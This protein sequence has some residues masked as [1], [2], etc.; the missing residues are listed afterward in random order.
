MSNGI[1]ELVANSEKSMIVGLA[2][3]GTGKSTTFKHLIDSDHYKGKKIL[4]LS[5]IR[6]LV[7][8]LAND[9]R[10]Y[11]KVKVA[12]LHSFALGEFKRITAS[13]SVDLIE[14]LDDIISEDYGIIKNAEISY[15]DKICNLTMTSDEEDFYKLRRDYYSK[16]KLYSFNS[17]VYAVNKLYEQNDSRIPNEYDIILIDEFQ[18]FN[19][20]EY[21]F[22]KKLN[23]TTKTL[24]VGDDDQS[25]YD[26]KFAKPALIRDLYN[27]E[28]TDSFSLDNCY[29]C[30]RVIVD[31][32]NSLIVNAQA[33]GL[34]SER[35]NE[36]KYLYPNERKDD[37][38]ELSEIYSK[39]DFMPKLQ[40]HQLTYQLAAKIKKDSSSYEKK[41]EKPARVLV[42][43]PHFLKNKL[44]DGLIDKGCNVVNYEL[45]SDEKLNKVK[46]SD[47]CKVLD[48]LYKRKT[49]DLMLRKVLH[50][51][52]DKDRMEDVIRNGFAKNKKIWSLLSDEEKLKIKEDIRIFRKAKIGKHTLESFELQR[53]SEIF[54]LKNLISKMIAGFGQVDSGAQEVG[55][56]TVMESKG[57]SADFVYF[58][59][60]DDIN[61]TDKKTKNLSNQNI[62]EFL[63]GMT[64]AKVK[65]T[66]F[67][68]HDESPKMLGLL[69]S[70]LVKTYKVA[71]K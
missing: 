61:M 71:E 31:A 35:I 55:L 2:G 10:E 15:T 39:I 16:N 56:V 54:C 27:D 68:M 13:K 45:F 49:D 40:G 22:I 3:P 36:K 34:L 43:A 29:R 53:L 38:H 42:I 4:I 28:D 37:K 60:I 33:K 12:T 50:L 21:E 69:D 20:L 25:L 67:S 32:V 26:W 1:V 41:W 66:L 19:S 24:I 64:R 70:H 8:D 58:V 44:Y 30:T 47:I 5:F 51:C 52:F 17:I 65:L 57:L 59:G 6:N 46:H 18:D 7:G 62:C 11:K 9:F 14:D 23:K 63:V 48:T